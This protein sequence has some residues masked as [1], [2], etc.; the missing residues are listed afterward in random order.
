M[1]FFLIFGVLV[2]ICSEGLLYASKYFDFVHSNA[3]IAE[4]VYILNPFAFYY[5]SLK[6]GDAFNTH[7]FS[8]FIVSGISLAYILIVGFMLR[9]GKK[10]R[11]ASIVAWVLVLTYLFMG[12]W[13]SKII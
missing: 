12:I 1:K 3:L 5:M 2:N 4:L 9:L 10:Y 13:I 7:I 8:H 6:S 11:I